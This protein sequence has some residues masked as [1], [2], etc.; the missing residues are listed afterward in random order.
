MQQIACKKHSL[1]LT[2]PITNEEFLSGKY[3]QDIERCQLHHKQY[4]ECRFESEEQ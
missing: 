1:L 4:P 2:I 3:H